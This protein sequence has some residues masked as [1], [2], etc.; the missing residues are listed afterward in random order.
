VEYEPIP[1]G[2]ETPIF[3]DRNGN[4]LS[5]LSADSLNVTFDYTNATNNTLSLMMIV[6]IYDEERFLKH[7]AFETKTINTTSMETFN[8]SLDMP[9]NING[10][11]DINGYSVTVFVW[12]TNTFIPMIEQYVFPQ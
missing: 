9:G 7:L 10:L 2:A 12:D 5:S 11:Y 6:A 4:L 8:V 3:K 1:A